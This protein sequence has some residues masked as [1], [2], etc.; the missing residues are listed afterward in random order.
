MHIY[1]EV[2]WSLVIMILALNVSFRVL[3]YLIISTTG[4]TLETTG[5]KKNSCF[6]A[7]YSLLPLHP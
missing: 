6:G 1:T 7:R 5:L 2:G 3:G 4:H